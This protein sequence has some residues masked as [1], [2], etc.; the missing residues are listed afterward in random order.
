[1]TRRYRTYVTN[2]VLAA[3]TEDQ[4]REWAALPGLNVRWGPC[5]FCGAEGW[6]L[7]GIP[8]EKSGIIMHDR[9]QGGVCRRAAAQHPNTGAV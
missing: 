1:M 3:M 7:S 2:A 8:H 4:Y 6:D 5:K 9:P